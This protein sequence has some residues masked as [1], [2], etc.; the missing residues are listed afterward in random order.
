MKYDSTN[1][2][3]TSFKRGLNIVTK[4]QLASDVKK[5]MVFLKIWYYLL[6]LSI[7]KFLGFDPTNKSKSPLNS[8]VK[9]TSLDHSTRVESKICSFSN[10]FYSIQLFNDLYKKTYLNS[11]NTD[12]CIDVETGIQVK[13]ESNNLWAHFS[14][15]G[16]EMI[17]TKCGRL[18]DNIHL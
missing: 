10:C 5:G 3:M 14:S 6:S 9:Q 18:G 4:D 17:I 16:T 1:K 8:T 11:T 15:I 13:L 2:A 7:L 12:V